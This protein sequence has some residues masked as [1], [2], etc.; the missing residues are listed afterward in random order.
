M[1]WRREVLGSIKFSQ[2][3]IKR[4]KLDESLYCGVHRE[5]QTKQGKWA[6]DWLV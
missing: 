1:E 6:H 2:E 4:R 5:E 3:A